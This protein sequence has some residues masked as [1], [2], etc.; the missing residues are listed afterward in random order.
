[1]VLI[2]P[3]RNYLLGTKPSQEHLAWGGSEPIIHRDFQEG[4]KMQR[5]SDSKSKKPCLDS[6]DIKIPRQN[7]LIRLNI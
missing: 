1:M 2:T 3:P 4:R 6:S 7:A 5:V